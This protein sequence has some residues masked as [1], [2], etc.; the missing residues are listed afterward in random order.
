MK[1]INWVIAHE[2]IDLF[3]R[4]ATKFSARLSEL[5]QGQLEVKVYTL[6]EYNNQLDFS[7][8]PLTHNDVLAEV[9]AGRVEMT[10]SYTPQLGKYLKDMHVLD[11]PFLFRDHDH[12]KKIL[13][14]EV[15][16]DLLARL[17]SQSAVRG[18]AFTYSGGFRIIPSTQAIQAVEDFRGLRLRVS[19]KSPI[20]RDT[21]EAVGAIPVP[22]V[23]E[24]IPQEV[25]A[26]EITGGESTYPRVYGMNQ[27]EVCGYVNETEHSLF[28][29]G[30]IIN[31]DFYNSLTPEQQQAIHVAAYE[32][33]QA[34][35][36]EAVE[37]IQHVKQRCIQ[38]GIK[39]VRMPREEL[40]LFQEKT[41]CVY[42]KYQDFFSPG[43]VQRII[44]T[45]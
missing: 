31:A 6:S 28:L 42:D 27:N 37:D 16:T 35:R 39:V 24:H 21:F 43:L 25:R 15:G 41:Q 38:D 29:T 26:G 3:L 36:V 13:D 9:E 45:K 44:N 2:P 10:Q 17:N 23:I 18:L 20:A 14:G 8:Q 4:A 7:Q 34:E 33:A 1:T 12:A 5:T 22:M 40:D 11:L 30:I 19:E 32:A